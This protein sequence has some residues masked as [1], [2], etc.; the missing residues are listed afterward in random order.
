MLKTKNLIID[1]YTSNDANDLYKMISN[2]NL[3][4]PAGFK[5]VPDMRTCELSLQYRIASK[6]YVKICLLDGSFIGEINF[7]KDSSKKNPN[8]YELGFILLQEYQ[9]FGYM[10]EALKA[11]IPWYNTIVNIDILSLHVF[12]NNLRSENTINS[13]NFHNDGI[14]RRYKQMYD[15][16]TLDVIEYSMTHEELERNIEIWQKF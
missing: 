1:F 15:G 13:L 3:T 12:T 10:Q 16:K 7:Y 8:A 6:Q 11:F 2:K 14:C 9:G 4:Y 5:P